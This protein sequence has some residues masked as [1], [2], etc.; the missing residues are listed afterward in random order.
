LIAGRADW[1]GDNARPAGDDARNAATGH[2]LGAGQ[3]RGGIMDP[4]RV[5]VHDENEIFRRGLVASLVE[6]PTITVV[7]MNDHSEPDL[8]IVSG[9]AA[10][11]QRYDCP[12]LV[13]SGG[14]PDGLMPANHVLG[15]L[16]RASLTPPQLLGAVHAAAAGLRV[17]LAVPGSNGSLPR[18][19]VVVLQLLADGQDTRRIA[20]EINCSERTVKQIVIELRERLGARNRAQVVAQAIRQGMI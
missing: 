20:R 13:C 9:V 12:I 11:D 3:V 6:D 8:A 10:R 1:A 17:E 5:R 15:V 14:V 4:I 19:Y 18:R 7:D 16:P 2:E